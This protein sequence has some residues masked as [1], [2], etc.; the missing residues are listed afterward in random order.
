LALATLLALAAQGS[1]A[2]AA[3]ARRDVFGRLPDGR[4]VEAVVLSNAHGL[5]VRILALGAIL[6][7]IEAPDRSGREADVL[8]GYDDLEGYLKEP[9]YFGASVGR[10]ANRIAKGRFTLDGRD[11]RLQVNDGENTLHGGP[12][13]FDRALWSVEEAKGGEA[14]EAVLTLTSPDGDQ[15]F[16]GEMKVRARFSLNE[17]NELSIV[18]EAQTDRPTVVNLTNHAYINLAGEGAASGALGQTLEIPAETFLPVD[19]GLIPTG[20][21][22]SV[23][24]TAFDFRRAKPVGRDV[25]AGSEEQLRLGRGYD[26]NFVL[27]RA[28]SARLHRAALLEDPVGG[29][30]LEILTTQPGLQLYSGNF[31]DGTIV[32]KKGHIYRQGDAVALEPQLFPD[33]P[34]QPAFGSARLA[35]GETYRH[36]I[37]YRFGVVP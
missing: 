20:E 15:G 30:T 16:P 12:R 31:L 21:F 27:A 10:Y 35:P 8:L 34:N 33:T 14:A 26:H 9:N 1:P 18:Y 17:A 28:P 29:R 5:K 23:S 6:Q 32:G 22:R 13:G 24:G 7:M 25:R 11:V 4:P 37:L 2:M 3:D 19:A 36:L